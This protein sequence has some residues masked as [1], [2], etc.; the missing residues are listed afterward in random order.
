MNT[1]YDCSTCGGFDTNCLGIVRGMGEC[2]FPPNT[3]LVWDE[4]EI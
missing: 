1:S 2:W 4:V 3:I